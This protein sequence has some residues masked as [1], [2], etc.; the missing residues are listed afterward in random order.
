MISIFSFILSEIIIHFVNLIFRY[1]IMIDTIISEIKESKELLSNMRKYLKRLERIINLIFM[2]EIILVFVFWYF[3]STFCAVY[4]GSQ[5]D[6]FKGGWT[7]FFITILF[8]FIIS[9]FVSM[10]RYFGLYCKS[11]CLYNCSLCLKVMLID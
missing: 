8:S 5:I 9:L 10:L 1:T 3:M 2:I 6:W 7:T 4:H 11:R